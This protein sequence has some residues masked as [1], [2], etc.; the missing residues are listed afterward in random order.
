MTALL[1]PA[2][3]GAVIADPVQHIFWA[4]NDFAG[5]VKFNPLPKK[6]ANKFNCNLG[7]SK[8][9]GNG[10][11]IG[12]GSIIDIGVWNIPGYQPENWNEGIRYHTLIGPAELTA[13][14]YNDVTNGGSPGAAIWRPLTNLW[15]YHYQDIQMAG[16][17][18]NAPLPMP[19]ALGEY[20]PVVGRAEMVYQNHEPFS[21]ANPFNFSA[22]SY[23]D[24]V[25]WMV[26]LDIDQAYAPWL[27]DTGNLSA[28]LEVFDQI[29]MDHKKTFDFNAE[30][31]NPQKNDVSLLFNIGTSWLW[32][33]IQPTYTMIF[34][35]KGRSMAIFPA[36][37]LNPPW[38]KKYFMKVQAIELLGGDKQYGVGF[39]KGQSMILTTFQYNFN[40]L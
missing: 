32:N 29:I 16:A 40:I 4:C 3:G 17:T 30:S 22:R 34:S 13:F 35:P 2:A 6:L 14:Y 9:Q 7:L 11:P 21:D 24:V 26:A 36:V 38:T 20:L 12:D 27:T 19:S 18:A 15:D 39:F 31:V 33:D 37:V 8:H 28:N 10:S 23:S 1:I 25:K 5:A